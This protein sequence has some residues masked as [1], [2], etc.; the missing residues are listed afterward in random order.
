MLIFKQRGCV[1][2][3]GRGGGVTPRRVVFLL[4]DAV[5]KSSQS[6]VAK[7]T[8]LTRLTVQRYLKGI[9]EPSR[10]TLEKLGRYF[11]KSLP[12]LLGQTFNNDD[13]EQIDLDIK[14]VQDLLKVYELVPE[15]LKGSV[16]FVIDVISDM[17][18]PTFDDSD[19]LVNEKDRERVKRLRCDVNELF[20]R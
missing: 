9:G 1:L 20:K 14:T 7:A 8:G 16:L 6:Q 17:F 18:I 2:A 12:W 15:E 3:R 13:R 11:N 5:S 19:D 4:A 10:D